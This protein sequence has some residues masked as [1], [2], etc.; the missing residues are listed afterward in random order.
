M[1]SNVFKLPEAYRFFETEMNFRGSE[2]RKSLAK[3]SGGREH[4]QEK[5]EPEEGE[6]HKSIDW[7]ETRNI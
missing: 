2:R 1:R 6:T 5:K 7:R 4:F 3:A